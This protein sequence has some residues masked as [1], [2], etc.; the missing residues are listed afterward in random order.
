[1]SDRDNSKYDELEKLAEQYKRWSFPSDQKPR[2]S[3]ESVEK[4]AP[5]DLTKQYRDNIPAQS[6]KPKQVIPKE[7][8]SVDKP[9]NAELGKRKVL[10]DK[11][12]TLGCMLPIILGCLIPLALM[13]VGVWKLSE[14]NIGLFF[15]NLVLLPLALVGGINVFRGIGAV[16][17]MD[18]EKFGHKV[19]KGWRFYVYILIHF[20]GYFALLYVLLKY[21]N[22]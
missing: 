6:P 11:L 7:N 20:G 22:L 17:E 9:V 12:S 4:F 21:M 8:V 3:R 14:G 16:I 10:A 18:E 15:L 5:T 19:K 1:M 2:I 13:F